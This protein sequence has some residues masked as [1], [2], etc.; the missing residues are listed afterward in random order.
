MFNLTRQEQQAILFLSISLLIGGLITLY[1]YQVQDFDGDLI[2]NDSVLAASPASDND[3]VRHTAA[4]ADST[5][6]SLSTGVSLQKINLNTAS[7][8]QL[9]TLPGVGPVLAKRIIAYREEIE[10]FGSVNQLL[11]V[12]GI[13]K[14]TLVKIVPL[15]TVE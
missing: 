13:G 2:L 14:A 9:Q 8:A 10:K 4:T 5:V 11:Q 12:K 3:Q 6:P 15:V 1:K 7:D